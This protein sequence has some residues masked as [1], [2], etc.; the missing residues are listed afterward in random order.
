MPPGHLEFEV[1]SIK[2]LKPP[3]ANY[4][5]PVCMGNSFVSAAA[6][7][8][9]VAFWAYGGYSYQYSGWPKWL[10]SEIYQIL[11]K[12]EKAIS[13]DKCKLMV[14]ELLAK[15]FKLA[16]HRET[17]QLPVYE[18]VIAKNG[19]KLQDVARADS[20]KRLGAKIN[21]LTTG[22]SEQK[23]ISM[24]DLAEILSRNYSRVGI[25]VV[26]RTGLR[27]VYAFTLNYAPT[28]SAD[29]PDL[30]TA[31]QEQLGLKVKS[32]KAPVETFAVEH[33]ERPSEN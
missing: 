30:F 3:P 20:T 9:V 5:R 16:L 11:A 33:V 10:E 27:G 19:P 4:Q 31:L 29:G 25:P 14:Q 32:T 13:E 24:A 21:G 1:A 12:A 23:G 28:P 18:L 8:P 17:K 2:S 15:R 7:M 26:D 6:P 22:G